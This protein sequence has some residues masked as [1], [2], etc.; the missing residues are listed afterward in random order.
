MNLL[1][2]NIWPI[3]LQHPALCIAAEHSNWTLSLHT[4]L[5]HAL[6]L[7]AHCHELMHAAHIFG[8]CRKCSL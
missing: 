1:V 4:L 3:Q 8:L 6:S 7:C 2:H 5:M